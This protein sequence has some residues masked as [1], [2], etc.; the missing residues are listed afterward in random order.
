MSF[1]AI[2]IQNKRGRKEPKTNH[3]DQNLSGANA[4]TPEHSWVVK[5]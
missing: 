2:V 5:K 3:A 4:P 1:R